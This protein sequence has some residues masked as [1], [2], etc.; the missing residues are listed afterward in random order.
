MPQWFRDDEDKH[1]RAPYDAIHASLALFT[2]FN[3]RLPVVKEVVDKFR[4]KLKAINARPI[5]KIAEAKA[6]KKQKTQKRWEKIKEKVACLLR[7]VTHWKW[8]LCRPKLLLKV[9]C[10]TR[11]RFVLLK[12]YTRTPRKEN[13][14]RCT[15]LQHTLHHHQHHSP[16]LNVDVL[17]FC[18]LS[19]I[20]LF[21]VKV[22]GRRIRRR[23]K[24]DPLFVWTHA[25][26]RT[27]ALW[28]ITSNAKRKV[29]LTKIKSAQEAVEKANRHRYNDYMHMY[30]F[31]EVDC[32]KTFRIRERK[33]TS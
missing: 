10:P 27:N 2:R 5:R 15:L 25:W 12:N 33:R 7:C 16:A 28:K 6:R 19:A 14:R 4:D 23:R 17:C 21:R 22:A 9:Q 18:R 24:Q 1:A 31:S 30:I 8:G 13:Q 20:M 26:K 29:Q 11:R 32:N 3:F